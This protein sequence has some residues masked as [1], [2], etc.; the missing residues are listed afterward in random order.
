MQPLRVTD[1]KFRDHL[2]HAVREGLAVV[3]ADVGAQ[4]D[5]IVDSVMDHIVVTKGRTQYLRVADR[6]VEYDPGFRY[7]YAF[8]LSAA[9]CGLLTFTVACV[10]SMYVIT[11][12]PNPAFSPELQSKTTVVDFTVTMD[13][14]EEQLLGLVI[15]HEQHVLEDQLH[16]I[17]NSVNANTK[18][19]HFAV[20]PCGALL[21]AALCGAVR[22][23]AVRWGASGRVSSI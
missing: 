22:C 14:L 13:S 7:A 5:T 17:L 16:Q 9:R 23:G 10:C 11:R 2:E 20:L 6:F 3:I 4:M 12:L 15:Q 1:D 18:V 19:L 8:E 21:C